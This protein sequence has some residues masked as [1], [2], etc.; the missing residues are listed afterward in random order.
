MQFFHEIEPDIYIATGKLE[1]EQDGQRWTTEYDAL[2]A[3][4]RPL[5]VIV[6]AQDQ[7]LPAA[8]RP[9][10]LWLKARRAELARLVR[11]T[12]YVAEDE[13]ERADMERLLPGR[14]KASPYPMAIAASEAE[15]LQK[16]RARL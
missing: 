3:R 16:A 11:V 2:L 1:T 7:P 15:A 13:A 12:F 10:V 9:M 14:S 6:N 8:G 5:I 4:G